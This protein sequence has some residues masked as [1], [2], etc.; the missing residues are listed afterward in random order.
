ME[1]RLIIKLRIL[2]IAIFSGIL[3]SGFQNCSGSVSLL[4]DAT[5]QTIAQNDPSPQADPPPDTLG[6][7]VREGF[8]VPV[9]FKMIPAGPE[10]LLAEESVFTA[11]LNSAGGEL[12]YVLTGK[13]IIANGITTTEIGSKSINKSAGEVY[14]VILKDQLNSVLVSGIFTGPRY[15]VLIPVCEK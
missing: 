14:F 4:S 12:V 15:S 3:L 9:C 13:L 7:I 5:T 11:Q 6:G 2:S 10:D 1:K 8:G